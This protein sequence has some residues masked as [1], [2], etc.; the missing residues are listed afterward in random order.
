ME[1]RYED[2]MWGAEC[3]EANWLMGTSSDGDIHW[4]RANC[5]RRTCPVC[6]VKR[7]RRIAWR[8]GLGI[9]EIGG[10]EG[11]GWV[12]GTFAKDLAKDVTV[13][14][15]RS[16]IRRVRKETKV[17]VQ[18]AATWELHKKGGLHVNIL[19]VP[20]TFVPQKDL[21][22]WWVR[23]GGRKRLSVKRVGAGIGVEAAKSMQRYG[24]YVAKFDQ[25]VTKGKGV[26]YSRGWPKLPGFGAVLERKGD[27]VWVYRDKWSEEA[28]TFRHERAKGY[29]QQIG[30]GEFG[31][32][33][34][35]RSDA[36]DRVEPKE[37]EG[38]D[39]GA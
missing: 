36:F 22:R 32:I 38:G 7:K 3:P 1:E 28:L 4:S 11:G 12:V 29:W 14:V 18:Y 37:L 20:W 27:V 26:A 10:E 39:C 16:F 35:D 33:Y 13:K 31:F 30:I 15:S 9:K 23:Y 25:M 34:G 21:V 8:I 17:N 6:G 5:K 19:M 2:L 24:N